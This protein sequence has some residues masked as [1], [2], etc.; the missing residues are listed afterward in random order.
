MSAGER[1]RLEIDDPVSERLW[2]ALSERKDPAVV[3]VANEHG[4]T[5]VAR[6]RAQDYV[7]TLKQCAGLVAVWS[8]TDDIQVAVTSRSGDGLKRVRIRDG[9][10]VSNVTAVSQQALSD[11]INS[12]GR[13][14]LASYD[15]YQRYF[16]DG[17]SA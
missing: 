9:L 14:T 10:V 15:D 7:R 4:D 1:E 12:H 11:L 13:P 6:P 3:R 2:D 8:L 5:A 16:L 17:D